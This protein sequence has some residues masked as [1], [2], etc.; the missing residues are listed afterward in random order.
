MSITKDE[1]VESYGTGNAKERFDLIY[2]NYSVFPQ[3]VDC[4]EIGLFNTILNEKEYNRRAKNSADLGVRV[5]TSNKSDP[6][7]KM[8]VE[9][10][11]IRE[12]IERC[13]TDGGI[14]KDTDNPEKH[15]KD[16]WTIAMMR[17]EYEVFDSFLNALK[18]DEYQINLT[19]NDQVFLQALS[20]LGIGV[21][22]NH[23]FS[24]DEP[25]DKAYLLC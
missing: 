22:Q 8:A 19:C 17:R 7:A 1:L 4:F 16:I 12:A 23:W 2:E 5:Q 21:S 24:S 11:M 3:L 6:T 9:R 20:S 13:D 10:V 15:K 14:L 18:G 25:F